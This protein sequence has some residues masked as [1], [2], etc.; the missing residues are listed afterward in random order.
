MHA[1]NLFAAAAAAATLAA[2]VDVSGSGD[3]ECQTQP[4]LET[5]RSADGDTVTTNIGLRFI[6]LQVGTGTVAEAC[7]VVSVQYRGFVAG[8]TVPFDSAGNATVRYVAGGGQLVVPGVDVG[9]I[10]M[11]QGGRRRLLIPPQLGFGPQPVTIG[12]R[13]IPAN[14][15][16]VFDVQ[17]VE[18]TPRND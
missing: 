7:D 3:F 12:G 9:V 11:R 6:D 18:V 10:G 16:L 2:C 17:V 13:T 5:S 4:P 1:R 14:S 8:D 15:D